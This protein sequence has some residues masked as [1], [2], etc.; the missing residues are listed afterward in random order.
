MSGPKKQTKETLPA[1]AGDP[2]TTLPAAALE[3]MEAMSGQGF[4]NQTRED[5]TI[6]VIYLLQAL[7]PQ[8]ETVAGAKAGKMLNSVT[9]ELYDEL[10]FVPASTSHEFVEYVPR[11]AGGGFVGVHAVGSDLVKHVKATQPFGQ[12]TNGEN[13]L[14]EFFSVFGVLC[15]D[16]QP[17]GMAVIRF[18]STKIKVYK[19]FNTRLQTCQIPRSTGPGRFTPALFQHVIRVS[20]KKEKN[21]HGEFYNFALQSAVDNNTIKSLI[22]PTDPRSTMAQECYALLK[23]GR[24]SATYGEPQGGGRDDDEGDDKVF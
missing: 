9:E 7:S 1:K 17:L 10:L 2:Q 13:E 4:E 3:S 21:A 22:P 23:E 11:K 19:Q 12:Y 20:T 5:I 15:D 18:K 6:P 14:V 24:V 16:S 8:L